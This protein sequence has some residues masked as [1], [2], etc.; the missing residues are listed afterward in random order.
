MLSLHNPTCTGG[1]NTAK[2]RVHF[3]IHTNESLSLVFSSGKLYE[4]QLAMK[5]SSTRWPVGVFDSAAVERRSSN[6]YDIKQERS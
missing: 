2:S 3:S 6:H 1:L 4:E 5:T